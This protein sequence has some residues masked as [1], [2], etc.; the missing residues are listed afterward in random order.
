MRKVFYLAI[1][2]I[3]LFYGCSDDDNSTES[4]LKQSESND[5]VLEKGWSNN[6]DFNSISVAEIDKNLLSLDSDNSADK[7]EPLD[8][9][10]IVYGPFSVTGTKS[11]H[12]ENLVMQLTS[13]R[14]GLP[15]GVY[16]YDAY[17]YVAAVQ[18]PAGM[19][20]KPYLEISVN[21]LGYTAF[22]PSINNYPLGI[23]YENTSNGMLIMTTLVI[24][25]KKQN[26][27]WNVNVWTPFNTNNYVTATFQYKYRP[28][29][30]W[31]N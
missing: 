19:E 6:L 23:I 4:S 16:T 9:E 10:N 21:P 18:L 25:I 2:A 11:I 24:H 12:A 31:K 15:P 22:Q 8:P 1:S 27:I 20:G 13:S 5:V 29:T 17:K 28:A 14:F 26:N 3:I 7:T 30:D